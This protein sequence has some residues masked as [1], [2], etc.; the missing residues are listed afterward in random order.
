MLIPGIERNY[1]C[2]VLPHY[3]TE[4]SGL[5]ILR[6]KDHLKNSELSII[7]FAACALVI[8]CS[9]EGGL[10]P[11][12]FDAEP[13]PTG[14]I[15]GTVTYSGKWPPPGEL[16]QLFFVPLPFKPAAVSEILTEFL[17]GNLAA[18]ETLQSN[19]EEDSFFVGDLD[20][21]AYVYNIIANQYGPNQF[22][23]WRPLGVYEENDGLIII[24]GDTVNIHIHVD[25][26]NLPPFPPE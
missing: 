3:L 22:T 7:I 4:C 1:L 17:Q 15:Q 11:P 14:A 12:P 16:R 23:D 9:C 5:I 26:D 6:K 21:G 13:E 2:L 19:V 20:N 10:E 18:S 8:L 24:E 25:F